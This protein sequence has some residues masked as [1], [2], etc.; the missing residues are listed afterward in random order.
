MIHGLQTPNKALKSRTFGLRQIIWADKL[1]SIWGIFSIH[2][3]IVSPL[4][5]FCI[6]QLGFEFEFEFEQQR[7]WDWDWDWRVSIVRGLRVPR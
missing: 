2:F 3:G 4:S 7:I 1:W 6:N 5:M